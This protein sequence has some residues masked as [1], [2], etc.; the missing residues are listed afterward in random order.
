MTSLD[1]AVNELVAELH[2]RKKYLQQIKKLA[3][4]QKVVLESENPQEVSGVL[5]ARGKIMTEV[6]AL[7]AEDGRASEFLHSVVGK[8]ETEGPEE[9]LG[10]AREI[11]ELVSEIQSIDKENMDIAAGISD[12][13]R[14]GLQDIGNHRRSR[15]VYTGGSKKITG[16]F[17]NKTR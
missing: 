11:E 10:V 1:E 8:G 17:V 9:A 12:D 3:Q 13:L 7:D 4:K 15:E 6:D 14:K 2:K 16:A 5:E